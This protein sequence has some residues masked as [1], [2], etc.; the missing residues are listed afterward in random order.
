MLFSFHV[1]QT[2]C[3]FWHFHVRLGICRLRLFPFLTLRCLTLL[4]LLLTRNFYS[5]LYYEM[6][7]NLIKLDKLSYES[8]INSTQALKSFLIAT[9]SW[10]FVFDA[11]KLAINTEKA[12]NSTKKSI[13][14]E[15][16]QPIIQIGQ[17][18]LCVFR[19]LFFS[20]S[21]ILI[22]THNKQQNRIEIKR[23]QY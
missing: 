23:K 14:N 10:L 5:R 13:N 18:T 1:H 21:L 4:R 8:I 11:I 19:C 17:L 7:L 22:R 2:V 3:D 16:K 20:F 6:S 9:I 12:R 15:N